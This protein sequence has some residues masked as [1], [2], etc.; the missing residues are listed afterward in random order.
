MKQLTPR[1]VLEQLHKMMYE[2]GMFCG[3][4]QG[5]YWYSIW[6]DL[7]SKLAPEMAEE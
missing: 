7:V 5:T 4:S 6:D 2:R 1:E 3:G